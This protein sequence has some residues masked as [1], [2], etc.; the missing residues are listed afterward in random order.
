MLKATERVDGKVLWAKTDGERSEK[1][2][3][4]DPGPVTLDWEID[5]ASYHAVPIMSD[6]TLGPPLALRTV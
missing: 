2:D 5:R 4:G 3:K 6:G 1:G